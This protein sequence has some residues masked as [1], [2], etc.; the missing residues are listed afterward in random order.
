MYWGNSNATSQSDPASVFDTTLGFAGVWHLGMPVGTTVPDATAN[1]NNGTTTA[2]ATVAGAIGMAQMFNG[3]SSLI[4]TSGSAMDKLN[5]PDSGTYSVSAWV[6]TNVLD[7]LFHGVVYKSN[8]EYGLQMRPKSNWEFFTYIDKTRWEMSRFPV[9]TDSWYLLSGVRRG[10]KQYLYVNGVCLDSTIVVVSTNI[11]RV[12]DQPL[13]I[14]HCPDG[15]TDPDRYFNGVIDEVRI[16]SVAYSADWI[17]LC[18]MNQ[19]LQ[20]EL[21]KW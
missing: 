5:F 6:K 1:G 12:Y 2:T 3:T 7:S 19:K 17:K 4:R 16:S 9:E 15:G 21:I 14:G 11:S 10:N 20:D 8:F 13:E 18:Y